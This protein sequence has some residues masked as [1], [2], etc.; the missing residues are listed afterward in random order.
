MITS[1][2]KSLIDDSK[3]DT[4]RVFNKTFDRIFD[5]NLNRT[6]N[7]IPIYNQNTNVWTNDHFR[8]SANKQ[9]KAYYSN[10]RINKSPKQD[11]TDRKSKYH[12]DGDERLESSSN[13]SINDEKSRNVHNY[14]FNPNKAPY[15]LN[16]RAPNWPNEN[17]SLDKENYK[18]RNRTRSLF[19]SKRINDQPENSNLNS[20][21]ILNSNSN[22][23]R[24]KLLNIIQAE[25]DQDSREI[26]LTQQEIENSNEIIKREYLSYWTKIN[27]IKL[28]SELTN[29]KRKIGLM[30]NIYSQTQP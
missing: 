11:E 7:R 24:S 19:L 27:F 5:R 23:N 4:I 15:N 20:F 25:L 22:N 30:P 13:E 21:E 29:L 12:I 6:F 8:P 16:K 26:P 14:Y 2:Q 1:F 18:Y 9:I 28:Y 17:N 3:D 10:P